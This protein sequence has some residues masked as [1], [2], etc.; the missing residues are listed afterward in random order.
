MQGAESMCQSTILHVS[1]IIWQCGALTSVLVHAEQNRQLEASKPRGRAVGL[2]DLITAIFPR[3]YARRY[4]A[5]PR[6][7]VM[8]FSSTDK[9]PV[10]TPYED[11]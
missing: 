3:I 7:R 2:W 1:Q 5:H 6:V 9:L 11:V 8:S 4:Y 10:H